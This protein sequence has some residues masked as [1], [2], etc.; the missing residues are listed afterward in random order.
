MHSNLLQTVADFRNMI[1]SFVMS[2][3]ISS[4][5]SFDKKVGGRIFFLNKKVDSEL[6]YFC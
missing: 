4:V 2:S 5:F 1:L 3:P 6:L